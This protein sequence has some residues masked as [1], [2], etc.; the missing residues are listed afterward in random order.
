VGTYDD[1]SESST[2]EALGAYLAA[3]LGL[4]KKDLPPPGGWSECGQTIGA[5][6]LRMNALS[7]EQIDGII[8]F[9]SHEQMLFGEIA[10]HLGYLTK[11][12][13]DRLLELQEFHRALELGELLVMAGRIDV[14]Q[15]CRLLAGFTQ[16]L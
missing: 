3:E 16:S 11:L 13:V 9:Q 10:I 6:A 7:I 8:D 2:R 12:E 1:R 4:S 5:L 14:P 15:L